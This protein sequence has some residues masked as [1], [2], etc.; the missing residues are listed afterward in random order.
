MLPAL[1]HHIKID[2]TIVLLI[3]EQFLFIIAITLP[4]DIR[5][6]DFDK[7]FNLKTI[8]T[9]IGVKK[10]II[11]SEVLLVLFLILKFQDYYIFETLSSK[12]FSSFVLTTFITM[13][14][15]ALSSK[16]RSELFFAGLV[17]STML[18]QYL[19]AVLL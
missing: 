4:F 6:L 3:V 1:N 19:G 7:D 12:Q 11:L 18:I 9:S 10:T 14:I 16:K 2:S 15:V 5:D 17:E 13:Y 8:P